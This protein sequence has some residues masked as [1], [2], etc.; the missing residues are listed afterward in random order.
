M[1]DPEDRLAEHHADPRPTHQL[2]LELCALLVEH[3]AMRAAAIV[4]ALAGL[5]S[6]A[7]AQV[8][9]VVHVEGNA[10]RMLTGR[11]DRFGWGGGG[12]VRAGLTLVGPLSVQ[13][14]Y[15]TSWF[16]VA[17][18]DPGNLHA[19]TLGLRGLFELSD[20]FVG[21]P[22]ADAN[23]GVGL[24]G[25]LARVTFDVGVGWTFFPHPMVGFGPFVRYAHIVQPNDQAIG[26]D[27]RFLRVGLAL[28]LRAVAAEEPEPIAGPADSDGDGLDDERDGCPQDAE[29]VDGFEDSDGCPEADNDGDGYADADDGCPDL[30]ETRNGFQDEDGCPDE[31]PAPEPTPVVAEPDPGERLPQ[32]VGFRTGSDRVSPRYRDAIE[33]VCARMAT[34]PNARLGVI[35]H[36]DEEG[37]A[38]GNH[39]LGAMRAGAVAE[40]LVMCGV[41]PQRIESRSF[42]DTQTRCEDTSRECHAR[43][44]RVEFILHR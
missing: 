38:A 33:A 35:G 42:G 26:A 2:G 1:L 16:P 15:G 23:V 30:A 25:G 44:R 6:V 27:A 28:T 7:E 20:G 3:L 37:T 41:P 36:A 4:L 19:V 17:D 18:Q 40:Q 12:A 29:D 34:E 5:G 21:G 8:R 9:P 43:N 32:T 11:Y 22:F 10:D 39:R 24:T 13:L 14:G 31:A